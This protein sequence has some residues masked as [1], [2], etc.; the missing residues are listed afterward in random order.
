MADFSEAHSEALEAASKE[1]HF[2]KHGEAAVKAYMRVMLK[3]DYLI[4]NYAGNA[5]RIGELEAENARLKEAL[6]WH[7]RTSDIDFMGGKS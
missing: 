4:C 6:D 5:V 2:A 7:N 3:H 1:C